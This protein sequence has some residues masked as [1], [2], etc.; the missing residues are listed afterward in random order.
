MPTA[1]ESYHDDRG[2]PL[3][4]RIVA[5]TIDGDRL[6]RT[7]R[8][9][10]PTYLGDPLNAVRIFSQKGA[11]ELAILRIDR[12]MVDR[13]LL[14]WLADIA[15]EAFMPIAYG[16]GVRSLADFESI[17]RLGFE[18]V[19]VNSALLENIRLASEAAS[20][21]GSQSVVASI[22]VRTGF[23]GR[24]QVRSHSGRQRTGVTPEEHAMACER[25]G[26]G[27][28]LLTSIDRDGSMLGYDESLISRV[29]R[30]VN[31]PVI[32]LGGAGDVRHLDAAHTAGAQA[33]AA[34]SLFCFHGPR[35]A[36]LLNY[37]N[38]PDDPYSD[39]GPRTAIG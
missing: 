4:R 28:I 22:D 32:A 27:E 38:S 31:V 35:R 29:S 1:P 21:F 14:H 12:P 8:F 10:R 37:P 26:C 33:A 19:I 17:I 11:D 23:L 3:R 9:R 16:G 13:N 25:A 7:V 30:R 34:G 18:K 36:V 2:L 6:V 24:M 20:R 39:P 15:A 5:L